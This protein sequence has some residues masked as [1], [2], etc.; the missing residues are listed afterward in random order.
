MNQWQ[1]TLAS[2][3][4]PYDMGEDE[5]LYCEVYFLVATNAR[6]V[7]FVGPTLG[8]NRDNNVE[9][10]KRQAAAVDTTNLDPENDDNWNPWFPVYGSDAYHQ[11]GQEAAN[12]YAER[13]DIPYFP[14]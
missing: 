6:G 1:V 14:V 12:L 2:D 11:S 7:R 13:N 3:T 5:M 10:I 4:R 9:E 8:N